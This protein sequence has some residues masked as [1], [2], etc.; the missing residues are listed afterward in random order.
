MMYPNRTQ[1]QTE[2]LQDRLDLARRQALV[3][4]IV[5]LNSRRETSAAEILRGILHET[6]TTTGDALKQQR[7]P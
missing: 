4:A 7:K 2:A 1:R 3:T 6:P 5:I